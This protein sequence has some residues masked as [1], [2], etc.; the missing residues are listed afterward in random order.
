MRRPEA[1]RGRVVARIK[2]RIER[3]QDKLDATVVAGR[4]HGR[5]PLVTSSA[6]FLTSGICRLVGRFCSVSKPRPVDIAGTPEQ[7]IAPEIDEIIFHEVRPF[8]QSE[9]SEALSEDALGRVERPR[10]ISH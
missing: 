2:E 3:V 1:F 5:A 6:Y 10:S 9:G 4:D 7:Q 8:L